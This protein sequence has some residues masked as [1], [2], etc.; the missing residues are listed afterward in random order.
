[1]KKRKGS[2]NDPYDPYVFYTSDG[3]HWTK[4]SVLDYIKRNKKRIEELS[5][6]FRGTIGD[7][8]NRDGRLYLSSTLRK[9]IN[10]DFQEDVFNGL[11]MDIVTWQKHNVIRARKYTKL[12]S[13]RPFERNVKLDRQFR[14]KIDKEIL[15]AC[16]IELYEKVIILTNSIEIFIMKQETW[17]EYEKSPNF[18]S[19]IRMVEHPEFRQ[20]LEHIRRKYLEFISGKK[21]KP[22][23]KRW[24]FHLAGFP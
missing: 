19:F 24:K 10:I 17:E 8:G 16:K 4:N 3:V 22:R 11:F 12:L 6:F 5:L 21:G 7:Y 2:Q 9:V 13:G 1:M 14:I 18:F 15:E 20:F 23:R